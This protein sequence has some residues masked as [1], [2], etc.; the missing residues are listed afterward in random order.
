MFISHIPHQNINHL[1]FA[2]ALAVAHDDRF[3]VG[4][5]TILMCN[6]TLCFLYYKIV[7]YTI[8]S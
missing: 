7:S 8:A 3:V 2:L 6:D 1:Q 4:F 5:T